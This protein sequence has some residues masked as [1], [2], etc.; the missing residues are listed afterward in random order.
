M[1][2]DDN[3][4]LQKFF[5]KSG[6]LNGNFSTKDYLEKNYP[7]VLDYLNKR[8]ND[9]DNLREN[10]LRIYFNIEKIPTCPICGENV[11]YRGKRNK[12]YNDSCGKVSCYCKIRKN[13]M[14]EKYGISNF[15]G[16][17]KSIEKSKNTKIERYGDVG[18]NNIEKRTKTCLI[19]Y[20]KPYA[21]N[22]EI[23]EKR[24]QTCIKKFGGVAPAKSKLV[25]NKMK[26]TCLKKY[27]VDNYRKCDECLNKIQESKRKNGTI[28]TSKYEKEIYEWLILEYGNYDIICQY[29][30]ERYKNQKNGHTYHCDFYI[31]SLDLFIEIQAYWAHGKHPYDENDESDIEILNAIKEKA[32]T[33]PIYNRMVNGW[34]EIDVEKRKVA[35]KNNLRFLECFDRNITK[36]KLLNIIKQ[37]YDKFQK[38]KILWSY[39]E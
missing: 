26:Q 12:L 9:S 7:D 32:K 14:I 39:F 24:K 15:G 5:G 21:V 18:Y 19:K 27:G 30:D 3:Y 10:F 29:K 38:S 17:K 6:K 11:S 20:N 35:I 8:Y 2:I 33:K 31:K 1:K 22:D 16:T 13:R 37:R 28:N 36:E 25:V 34:A 23:L 4:I